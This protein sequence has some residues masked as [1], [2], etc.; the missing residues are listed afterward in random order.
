MSLPQD[1]T[2]PK[3]FEGD[4]VEGHMPFRLRNTP[5]SETEAEQSEEDVEGHRRHFFKGNAERAQT[6]DD[7]VE[8]HGLRRIAEP[9]GEVDEDASDVEGHSSRWGIE[10]DSSEVSP[11][12]DDVEGHRR[13]RW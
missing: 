2:H 10:G 13:S 9:D 1:P 6:D 3:A 7:D 11:A 8:A 4:D 12:D 5:E